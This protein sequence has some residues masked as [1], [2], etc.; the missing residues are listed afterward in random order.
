MGNGG[1]SW[2]NKWNIMLKEVCYHVKN[3]AFCGES[4]TGKS[5]LVNALRGYLK[6]GAP[7]WAPT[8]VVETTLEAFYYEHLDHRC[9]LWDLPGMGTCSVPREG[10][11]EATGLQYF[12]AIVLVVGNRF[13]EGDEA[14][15]KYCKEHNV[16]LAVVRSK[17]D[18]LENTEEVD[19]ARS[20]LESK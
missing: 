12:D 5:S 3:V 19:Q 13:L 14:V 6:K 16:A 11:V 9:L 7:G 2:H 15:I 8:G 17:C 4:G 20:Y 1:V 18:N 10:Y